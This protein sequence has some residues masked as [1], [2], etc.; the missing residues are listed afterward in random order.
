MATITLKGNKEPIITDRSVA[1]KIKDWWFDENIPMTAKT[2][3]GEVSCLKG[4]IKQINLSAMGVLRKKEDHWII[5]S[6]K[7]NSIWQGTFPTYEMA[8]EEYDRQMDMLHPEIRQE[9]DWVIE[10]R[11]A[12]IIEEEP[13][14]V[15][16]DNWGGF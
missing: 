5:I 13:K 2:D 12:D 10:K 11:S 3:I 7:K 8:K 14:D 4:E 16:D 9:Q 1:Q 15:K 6:Y